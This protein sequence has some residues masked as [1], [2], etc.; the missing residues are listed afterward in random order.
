MTFF[1]THEQA[2]FDYSVTASPPPADTA[3]AVLHKHTEDGAVVTTKTLKKS[4]QD[5]VAFPLTSLKVEDSPL[6]VEFLF[7][8]AKQPTQRKVLAFSLAE[9]EVAAEVDRLNHLTCLSAIGVG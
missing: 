2:Q 3:K 8:K 6:F 9:P 7:E 5:K 4:G 1:F